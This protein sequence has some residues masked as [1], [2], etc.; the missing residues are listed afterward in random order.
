MR[1]ECCSDKTSAPHRMIGT[2]AAHGLQFV[3]L[4]QLGKPLSARLIETKRAPLVASPVVAGKENEGILEVTTFF[5][6]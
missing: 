2:R 4:V 5:E 1:K 6:L 3:P